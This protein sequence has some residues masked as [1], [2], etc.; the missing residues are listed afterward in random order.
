MTLRD[1]AVFSKLMPR[2]LQVAQMTLSGGM[3]A[4]TLGDAAVFSNLMPRIIALS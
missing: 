1:A 4:V 3:A 2:L